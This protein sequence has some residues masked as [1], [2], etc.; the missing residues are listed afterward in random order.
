M[1][2]DKPQKVK[3]FHFTWCGHIGFR[4]RCYVNKLLQKLFK[5]GNYKKKY[6]IQL[7]PLSLV[8]DFALWDVSTKVNAQCFWLLTASISSEIIDKYAHVKTP[9]ILNKFIEIQ[10]SL[11]F[12]VW[13]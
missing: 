11:G 8:S 2:P 1:D 5:G 13:P 10:F 7:I 3:K 9:I 12:I 6:G 4:T